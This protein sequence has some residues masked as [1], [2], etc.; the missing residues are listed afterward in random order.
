MASAWM[1][2]AGT[3]LIGFGA[4]LFAHG[5]LTATMNLAPPDQAGLAL[6]AWGAVQASAA[7]VAIALGG[8]VRDVVANAIPQGALGAAAGYDVVYITELALL[9]ATI[10][11]MTPLLPRPWTEAYT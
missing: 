11:A 4:G 1:F 5:T 2:G 6:G 3:L 8:I 10:V 9:L 7:G